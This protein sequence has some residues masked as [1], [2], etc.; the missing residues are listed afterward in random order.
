MGVNNVIKEIEL[1]ERHPLSEIK[2]DQK[3]L[4]DTHDNISVYLSFS[5]EKN[6]DQSRSHFSHREKELE[7]QY[8][9]YLEMCNGGSS[10]SCTLQNPRMPPLKHT[11]MLRCST[12]ETFT[13]RLTDKSDFDVTLQSYSIN[14]VG[15]FDK[16]VVNCLKDKEMIYIAEAKTIK[17]YGIILG[18]GMPF[19]IGIIIM[20][21]VLIHL[22]R[23]IKA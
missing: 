15:G 11:H 2:R 16:I 1:E 8:I 22:I 19:L 5:R 17:L 12:S 13:F 18:V 9:V 3:F 4:I 21:G 7:Y 20:M 23:Y 10:T 6:A 14:W